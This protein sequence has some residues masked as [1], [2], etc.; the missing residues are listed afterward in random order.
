MVE[1]DGDEEALVLVVV[2]VG[3]ERGGRKGSFRDAVRLVLPVDVA[4]R[5]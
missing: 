2:G 3:G 1:A 4:F 5:R